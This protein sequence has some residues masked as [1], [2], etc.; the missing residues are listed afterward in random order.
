[1]RLD[2]QLLGVGVC[3]LAR[4]FA[5]NATNQAAHRG[6]ETARP[7]F[8][9]ALTFAPHRQRACALNRTKGEARGVVPRWKR[10]FCF[11]LDAGGVTSKCSTNAEN[12]SCGRSIAGIGFFRFPASTTS[13]QREF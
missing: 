2:R 3:R 5:V 11:G 10:P 6:C 8:D 4:P 9:H 12:D 13:A 7:P 1:M